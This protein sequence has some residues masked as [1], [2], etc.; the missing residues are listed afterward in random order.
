MKK[1]LFVCTGNTCRS[2]MAEALFKEMLQQEK[3]ADIEVISAGTGAMDGDKA[4]LQARETMK[5]L[6][7]N[8]DKHRSKSLSKKLINEADLILTMTSNH[9][10][11]VLNIAPEAMGKVYTLKE[12]AYNGEDMES[13][14]DEMNEIYKKINEK[15]RAFLDE[16]SKRLH[17]LKDKREKLLKELKTIDR[18]VGKLEEDFRQ[19][20]EK[21]EDRL[22]F[23]RSRMPN[24]DIV[25]P[26]G[27]PIDA[28]RK[29]VEEIK[30][31]LEKIIKKI[32]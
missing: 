2:S 4:S 26:F 8:I 32:K 31:N 19:A 22:I 15:K 18:S 20:I 21:Y 3:E 25:D 6:G 9:K 29:S 14:M 30:E 1:I 10:A 24:F 17:E 5:E 13:I 7:M 28:Y 23:L 11:T 12:Y 27:Q 16:N